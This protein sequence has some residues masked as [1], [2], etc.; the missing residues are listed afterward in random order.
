[1]NIP[2]SELLPVCTPA[3]PTVYCCPFASCLSDFLRRVFCACFAR[4]DREPT[5]GVSREQRCQGGGEEHLSGNPARGVL[6]L[7]RHQ[8]GRQELNPGH[9]IRFAYQM[10]S[11]ATLMACCC[12]V[13]GGVV[14]A[15][16]A[17]GGVNASRFGGC[18][19]CGWHWRCLV[20]LS[21]SAR[22]KSIEN[23]RIHSSAKPANRPL[24]HPCTCHP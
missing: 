16:S 6:R 12:V 8:W 14:E 3:L 18:Y 15:S 11:V 7:T 21:R 5:Q 19:G 1:M 24:C 4:S 2:N 20:L 17:C 9:S 23:T 22:P 13:V 10:F